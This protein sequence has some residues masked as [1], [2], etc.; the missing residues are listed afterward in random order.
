MSG[1][2]PAMAYLLFMFTVGMIFIA[3]GIGLSVCVIIAVYHYSRGAWL[4][5]VRI[6]R[7]LS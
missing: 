3:V 2:E 5:A 4:R 6:I 1:T 7:D